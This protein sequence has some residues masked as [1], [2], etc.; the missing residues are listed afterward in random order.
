MVVIGMFLLCWLGFF[1]YKKKNEGADR[2]Y[3]IPAVGGGLYS[4]ADSGAKAGKANP[5]AHKDKAEDKIE[6]E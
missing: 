1:I 2:D 5:F 3:D 4:N 6:D